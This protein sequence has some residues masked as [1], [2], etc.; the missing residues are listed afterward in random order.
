M[1]SYFFFQDGK[2]SM[3]GWKSYVSSSVKQYGKSDAIVYDGLALPARH[4]EQRYSD[5]TSHCDRQHVVTTVTLNLNLR[6]R[7]A[8]L[9]L[10]GE[11]NYA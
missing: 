11:V 5:S 1:Q 9:L 10:A 8:R 4:G 2:S 6:M 7:L 3:D